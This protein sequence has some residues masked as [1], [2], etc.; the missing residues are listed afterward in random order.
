MTGPVDLYRAT[1][2]FVRHCTDVCQARETVHQ[3]HPGARYVAL[4]DD[5]KVIV[6]RFP[7]TVKVYTYEVRPAV[8]AKIVSFPSRWES[9]RRG[10]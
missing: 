7:G 10:A 3:L 1:G 2:D 5:F 9:E 6:C 4:S 8:S